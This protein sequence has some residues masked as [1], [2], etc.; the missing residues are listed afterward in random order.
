MT[1]SLYQFVLSGAL[2]GL[3]AGISPG[4]LLT[5]VVAQ[6]IRHNRNEGIK[7]AVS[8]L[9]TDLPI[10]S[11]AFLLY[12]RLTEFDTL[13]A[14]IS[15][16]GGL[17]VAWLGVGTLRTKG[18]DPDLSVDSP[19]SMKKGIIAN[20]LS[21]HAYLFWATVGTPILFRANERSLLAAILFLLSFYTLLV[22]SKITVA[23]L[24]AGTKTILNQK[25]YVIITR[26]LGI[27]LLVFSLLFFYE[28]ISYLS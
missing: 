4:P 3:T 17:F 19:G 27:V 25:V 18:F 16:A 24:V 1:E 14:A 22:G 10:I 7:V 26:V 12:T 5:L 15:F 8:P 20:F 6:T 11:A 9:I 13:L 28:G 23:F 2:L 21:P